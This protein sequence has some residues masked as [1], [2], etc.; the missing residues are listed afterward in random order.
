MAVRAGRVQATKR[1]VHGEVPSF[2]R[3]I[4]GHCETAQTMH[5]G[6]TGLSHAVFGYSQCPFQRIYIDPYTRRQGQWRYS[7]RRR[8]VPYCKD[9]SS[10]M[11]TTTSRHSPKHVDQVSRHA[12]TVICH[13]VRPCKLPLVLAP[14]RHCAGNT[15]SCTV[16]N[17]W[18]G[19]TAPVAA[20]MAKVKH[21]R[22][23]RRV[24]FR[25]NLVNGLPIHCTNMERHRVRTAPSTRRLPAGCWFVSDKSDIHRS[26]H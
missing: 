7:K 2:R 12:R 6:N 18:L 17:L 8:V 10:S 1:A 11:T 21:I 5:L 16:R 15:D 26:K 23:S 14:V 20:L 19:R 24:L 9:S 3:G 25:N 4:D 13:G 22:M